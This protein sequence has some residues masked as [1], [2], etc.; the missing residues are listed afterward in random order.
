M[1]LYNN[2]KKRWPEL[3]TVKPSNLSKLRV[4]SASPAFNKKYFDELEK[5]LK[6]YDLSV[7]EYPVSQQFHHS[8]V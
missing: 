3:H 4:K 1:K 7:L 6:K 8:Q 5:M 2:F